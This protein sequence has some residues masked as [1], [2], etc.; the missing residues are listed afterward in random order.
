MGSRLYGHILIMFLFACGCAS[1]QLNY[2]ILTDKMYVLYSIQNGD[3]T[4]CV[5]Y[6]IGNFKSPRNEVPKVIEEIF[7]ST[8][9]AVNY[10]TYI[11][12]LKD[13]FCNTESF[14]DF[15][16]AA[17]ITCSEQK[18]KVGRAQVQGKRIIEVEYF[19]D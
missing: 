1:G 10:P 19:D 11:F 6:I 4:L 12:L 5:R 2:R 8:D 18:D 15:Y 13:S 17:L 3:T 16:P 7:A 9:I 14:L